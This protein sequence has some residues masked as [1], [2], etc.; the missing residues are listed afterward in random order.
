MKLA[1]IIPYYKID[2]F[3]ETLESL[4]AQTDKRFNVYIGDDASP[5]SPEDLL[6]RYEGKFNFTYKRFDD[7]LGSKSLTKQWE[8][9][10]AMMQ[11]EEWFM[12]LGD[13]D[14]LD[15]RVIEE[16]YRKIYIAEQNVIN[17]IKCSSVEIEEKDIVTKEKKREP[18][19]KS[20]IDHFFD[21]FVNE[22]R[23]SLTE[24]IFRK[25]AYQKYGFYDMPLAWHSDDLAQL[26]FS[27]FGDILFL[28]KA[29]CYIRVSNSSISG[30][31]TNI[32]TKQ[33]SSKIFFEE[34]GREI[35]RFKGENLKNFLNLVSWAEKQKNIKIIINNKFWY[36]IKAYGFKGIYLYINR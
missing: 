18:L 8:R 16:F 3:E 24:H 5:D 9:C 22:G 26:Q 28:E 23:S 31:K 15:N 35:H 20:S 33:L 7:N 4:A 32:K 36:Y 27:E 30:D 17:I 29:K 25:T 1:I 19:I 12:I 34:L 6:K 11:D 14:Y 13:D 21:K 10:I 2:F